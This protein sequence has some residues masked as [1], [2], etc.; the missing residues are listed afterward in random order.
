MAGRFAGRSRRSCQQHIGTS[1]DANTCGSSRKK[2]EGYRAYFAY[3]YTQW[4]ARHRGSEQIEEMEIYFM[5]EDTLPAYQTT[6]PQ[7]I[8]L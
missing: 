3:Y 1:G 6:E 4:N 8:L 7:R 5:R 2:H